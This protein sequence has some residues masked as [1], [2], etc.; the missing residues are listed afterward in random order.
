MMKMS[1]DRLARALEDRNN[2]MK[3][4]NRLHYIQMEQ[5]E[6]R[7]RPLRIRAF[8]SLIKKAPF[9]ES[10]MDLKMTRDLNR[11]LKSDFDDDE[12]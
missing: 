5:E 2:N 10:L 4:T 6:D 1:K 8:R 12:S 3:E 7:E 11:V 9:L